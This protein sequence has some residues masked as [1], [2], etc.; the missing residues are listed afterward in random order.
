[1]GSLMTSG[2]LDGVMV[3][4]IVCTDPSGKKPHRQVDVGVVVT[5]GSLGGGKV[6]KLAQNTE[7]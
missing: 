6:S 1:M 4:V 2:G 7:K 3:R 5:S